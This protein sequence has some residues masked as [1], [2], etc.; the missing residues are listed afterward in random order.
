MNEKRIDK[1]EEKLLALYEHV[2]NL[3]KTMQEFQEFI[4]KH[5]SALEQHAIIVNDILDRFK[6]IQQ[7]FSGSESEPDK[8]K[9]RDSV[10]GYK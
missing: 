8:S 10:E 6:K 1:I 3:Y 5:S 9:P 4:K 7:Q 2:S